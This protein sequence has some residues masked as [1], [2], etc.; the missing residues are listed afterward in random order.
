MEELTWREIEY[1]LGVEDIV[2]N[3][4]TQEKAD[5]FLHNL[6]EWSDGWVDID[7]LLKSHSH[8]FDISKTCYRVN[9]NGVIT[10]GDTYSFV[11]EGCDIYKYKDSEVKT[12]KTWELLKTMDEDYDSIEHK[13]FKMIDNFNHG[14]VEVGTKVFVSESA[15]DVPGLFSNHVRL[16][17][18]GGFEE[19]VE[20]REPLTL[21]DVFEIITNDDGDYPLFKFTYDDVVETGSFDTVMARLAVMYKGKELVKVLQEGEWFLL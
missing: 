13:Q 19:W 18:I 20:I 11:R 1:R 4:T 7:G 2:I 12:Y 10:R 16:M 17:G 21:E 5:E 14:E 15:G 8:E 3:C 9:R 6:S